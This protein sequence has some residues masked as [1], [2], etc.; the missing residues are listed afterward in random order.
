[1]K[2]LHR[3]ILVN[4]YLFESVEWEIR[5]ATALIGNN[6]SGKSSLID[7]IQYVMIG[8]NKNDWRPNA[9][10]TNRQRS[11]DV[12]SYVL[13]IIKDEGATAGKTEFQPRPDALCRICLVFR[14]EET[15]QFTSVGA[16]VSA[17]QADHQEQVEGFFIAENL[18]M[19]LG[20]FLESSPEGEYPRPYAAIRESISQR[21]ERVG[22][23]YN[24]GHDPK[25]F[26][27]QLLS[28]LGPDKRPPALDKYRRSFRQSVYMSALEGS[29]SDFVQNSILDEKPI[30]IEQMRQ[31]I[32]SYNNKLEAVRRTEDQV[33]RLSVVQGYLNQAKRKAQLS[34]GYRW[35]EAEM[36]FQAADEDRESLLESALNARTKHSHIHRRVIELKIRIS[37]VEE[38][39]RRLETTLNADESQS[40]KAQLETQR[41]H[42]TSELRRI[43]EEMEKLQGK[44]AYASELLPHAESLPTEFVHNL[45]EMA[46]LC[47]PGLMAWPESPEEIDRL[48]SD[49]RGEIDQIIDNVFDQGRGIAVEAEALTKEAKECEV[50]LE[51]LRA[52]KSDLGRNTLALIEALAEHGIEATPVCEL[53]EVTDPKW[54]P[55][56]E[57]FL[58]ARTQ[59]LIVSPEQARAAVEIYRTLK[60]TVAYGA[61]VV[62]TEKVQDWN[63]A[64]DPDTAPTLISGDN[65]LAIA[66]VQRLL[67]GMKLCDVDTKRLIR[68]K[69]A[70]SPDGMIVQEAS[71]R[72]LKLPEF[73]VLGRAARESQIQHMESKLDRCVARLSV[74]NAKNTDVKKLTSASHTFR[75]K[76]SEQ[77]N[78]ARRVQRELELGK[79]IDDLDRQIQ[80]IDTSH[81]QEIEDQLAVLRNQKSQL[82]DENVKSIGDRRGARDEFHVK[83]ERIQELS[84]HKIPRLVEERREREHDDDYDAQLAAELLE[85]LES[86]EES[87]EEVNCYSL[88]DKAR[89]EADNARK[90][91]E[92]RD[93]KAM[94]GLVEYKTIYPTE[95]LFMENMS[96][97]G[98]RVKV[99][100]MLTSLKEVGLHERQEELNDAL[101]RV[102][103]VFRT[104]LA[105]K[106]RSGID[107][108]RRRFREL[109]SELE[110]RPFS[111]N[112]LYQFRF[113][114]KEEHRDFIDYVESVDEHAAANVDSLFDEHAHI[115]SK[116]Q[117][118]LDGDETLSDYREY[119]TYDIEIQDPETGIKENLSRR[120]GRASGGEH[121]TPFYVAMGASLASAYRINRREDGSLDGGLSLYLADEAFEKMDSTNTRQATEYL[122]S[123]GLQLFVAT[124]DDAEPRLRQV[125]DTVLF[126]TREGSRVSVDVD[127]VTPAARALLRKVY[128]DPDSVDLSPEPTAPEP[129]D[130]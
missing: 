65:S 4:W 52:G 85:K 104:D 91:M 5:G 41:N 108:M 114:R 64:F 76:I 19:R 113:Q 84:N 119:F 70:M 106:L 116:V 51:R 71:V 45:K 69:R 86:S 40:A 129:V 98:Y 49:L 8:G 6:G 105:I 39:I 73:P 77:P 47:Q 111:S 89:K 18:E 79:H 35:C 95:D 28:S 62:N 121:K 130:G 87:S 100:E 12:R 112:Q 2:R 10:A 46:R 27:K 11:R 63:D 25:N 22:H 33:N 60:K 21:V 102:Q 32:E 128:D 120:I 72:R 90:I 66:Y 15:G 44:L 74:L 107:D 124:P 1:M 93:K 103:N 14:D 9:K 94:S 88:A 23:A 37:V 20:D 83:K 67:R 53:V 92:E 61:N 31:S 59:A 117:E 26:V 50:A 30:N 123:V 81:L 127:H 75:E 56:I 3:I 38:R 48:V 101:R 16:A 13:G 122:K 80:A 96:P 34:A 55:A 43:R 7:A 110:E 42:E 29:V 68:E 36:R 97:A 57:A 58:G 126:F 109:N 24:F 54:Q 17:R 118:M 115:N 82:S 78:L 99:D 125:V